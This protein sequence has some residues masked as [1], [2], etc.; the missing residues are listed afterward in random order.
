MSIDYLVDADTLLCVEPY[1]IID[2]GIL[3]QVHISVHTAADS[4]SKAQ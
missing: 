4:H 1:N 3:R 2:G